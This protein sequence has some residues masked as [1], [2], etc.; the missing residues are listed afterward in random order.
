MMPDKPKSMSEFLALKRLGVIAHRGLSGKAPE[1]TMAA[2][3]LAIDAGA[4][5]IELDVTL[6]SDGEL[7]VIH[8]DTLQATTNGRGKVMKHTLA[9][10]RALDAGSWFGSQFTGERLPLLSEVLDLV[11]SKILLNIE[12][13]PEAVNESAPCNIA[14]SIAKQVQDRGMRDQVIV[15]SF[16]PLAL[17]EMHE[18]DPTIMTAALHNAELRKGQSPRQIL[19][20]TF[21]TGFNLSKNEVTPAIVRDCKQFGAPVMVYT[22]NDART[23]KRMIGMGVTAIFTDHADAALTMIA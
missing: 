20:E 13:K 11:R 14:E 21:A 22:V 9:E 23:T 18:A 2:F 4:D 19:A 10:L 12:I 17:I 15:S 3:R 5:M 7:V 16:S 1:N 6:T 8:D